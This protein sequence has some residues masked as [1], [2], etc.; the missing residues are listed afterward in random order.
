MLRSA[1][2]ERVASIVAAVFERSRRR[3]V[4]LVLALVA[5]ALLSVPAWGPLASPGY[6]VFHD[7]LPPI[8]LF[9]MDRCFEDGQLPCR[10]APDLNQGYGNPLFNYYAP[11]PYYVGELIHLSGGG[12]LDTIK[13]LFIVGFVMSGLFMFL[14]AREFWG[15]LG[16]LVSAVFYV[17]APYH[18]LDVYVRG[19]LNE[20]WGI[21]FFPAV[22]WGIYKVVKEGRPVHVMLLALFIFASL[23]SHSLTV[24][25]LFPL[26]MV[27]AG[28]FLL[29]TRQWMRVAHLAAAGG[30]G[31]ALGAFFILPALF[32]QDFTQVEALKAGYFYYADHFPTMKQLF[33]TRFWG[34]GLSFPG[35]GDGISFQIG[36]LHWGVTVASAL[37][38]PFLWWRSR[39]AFYAVVL[40]FAFFWASVFMMQP[41]SDFLWEKF[42]WLK[43]QQFPWRFLSL[44][45]FTSSFLA[46][47]AV[48]LV[49]RR[50]YLGVLV[51]VVLIGAVVGLN[52]EYFHFGQRMFITDTQQFS[53]GYW[54][55]MIQS[56]PD[57]HPSY[58]ELPAEPAPALVQVIGGDATLTGVS[59]ES[60]SLAFAAEST[61]GARLRTS[62]VDF[63]NWRVRVDGETIEHDHANS[64]AAIS[65]DLV[66]GSHEVE[67]NLEDTALR[68]FSNYVSLAAWVLF[69]GGAGALGIRAPVQA[70][71]DSVRARARSDS[72]S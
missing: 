69:V 30:A 13:V 4:L 27:W 58:A 56:L 11:L 6:P 68:T 26:A 28:V 8:R 63:P 38:A 44:A 54:G 43:W 17:Y 32:E 55:H 21:A 42:D 35:D 22:L 20:H 29:L 50:R 47:A 36:W 45:I 62:V 37:A 3:G 48:L 14:L 59:Q 1:A 41:G 33:V 60:D 61:D 2:G 24:M 51:S 49:S 23:L 66:P 40:A 9:E 5:L 16:G 71:R 70:Y 39:A 19:S 25:L 64:L 7:G 46:G 57:Y 12:F 31:F 18:A 72:G 53:E 10:W 67:L 34:Y 65:F 52:Q 15:N